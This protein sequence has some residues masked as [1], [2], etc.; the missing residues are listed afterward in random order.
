MSEDNSLTIGAWLKKKREERGYS[1]IELAAR[2]GWK[3]QSQIS[4]FEGGRRA[5]SRTDIYRIAEALDIPREEIPEIYLENQSV[6]DGVPPSYALARGHTSLRRASV[7][8]E[9][10]YQILEALIPYL[11]SRSAGNAPTA[12]QLEAFVDHQLDA[13]LNDCSLAKQLGKSAP[14]YEVDLKITEMIFFQ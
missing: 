3:T 1:Q 6:R 4:L 11:C 13:Y 2:V 9:T 10:R 7:K 14:R 12:K 8:E 5:I